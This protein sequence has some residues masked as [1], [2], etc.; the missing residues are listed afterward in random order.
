MAGNPAFNDK[1]FDKFQNVGA[2][3]DTDRMTMEGTVTKG[4][5]LLGLAVVSATFAWI[6]AATNPGAAMGLLL[7]GA[8]GGFVTAL[9]T[10]F[11]P[12]GAA[13]TGPIYALLEGLALGTISS[14]F[15]AKIKGIVLTAV[16]ITLTLLMM[17]FLLYR[18]RI[19]RATPVFLK[20]VF[21]A[22]GAIALSYLISMV[23]S[24]FGFHDV[25]G[26]NSSGPLGIGISL[27]IIVVACL[28]FVGDFA[29]IERGVEQGSPKFMEWY[30]AFGVMVTLF[31]LYLE[32]LRLLAKLQGNS[33]N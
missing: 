6:V 24:M 2:Q 20:V 9:I 5:I 16:V 15:D 14:L 17:M 7:V 28:N 12:Q 4:L 26:L 8:L 18:A 30:A 27:V 23:A 13:I 1:T 29:L 10:A 25:L 22:T 11:R 31:W 21:A 19:I 32:V 3:S 33:R